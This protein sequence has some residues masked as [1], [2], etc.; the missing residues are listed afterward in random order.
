MFC[1]RHVVERKRSRRN[2]LIET[3]AKTIEN[4]MTN[5]WA[6]KLG[7][8]NDA[9]SLVKQPRAICT[10]KLFRIFFISTELIGRCLERTLERCV[11]SSLKK[12]VGL[13][14]SVFNF[15]REESNFTSLFLRSKR[16]KCGRHAGSMDSCAG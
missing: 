11:G 1:S 2:A 15:S 13:K 14:E 16:S 8:H 5:V 7:F 3:F 12:N 9:P 10:M 4:E 6:K